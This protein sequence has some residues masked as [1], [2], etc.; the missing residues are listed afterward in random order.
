MSDTAAGSLASSPSPSRERGKFEPKLPAGPFRGVRYAL[1]GSRN[2][3][4]LAPRIAVVLLAKAVAL[5]ILWATLVRGQGVFVDAERTAAAF[6]IGASAG[7]SRIHDQN[8]A[9][10]GH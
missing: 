6:G 5:A 2:E 3:M 10:N 8:G 1:T 7:T 4:R 9:K